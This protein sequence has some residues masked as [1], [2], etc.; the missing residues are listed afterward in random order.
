M[1]RAP[2]NREKTVPVPGFGSASSLKERQCA[3]EAPNSISIS[4]SS[5]VHPNGP[6]DPDFAI[7]PEFPVG[8]GIGEVGLVKQKEK[9]S[10][11]M[12]VVRWS[13]FLFLL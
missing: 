1:Y 12:S 5:T 13:F 9:Q 8:D 11:S 6:E 10:V 3:E 2:V 7:S 4:S